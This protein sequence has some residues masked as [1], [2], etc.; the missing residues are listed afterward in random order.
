MKW[1]S[2]AAASGKAPWKRVLQELPGKDSKHRP[3]PARPNDVGQGKNWAAL[4]QAVT[5]QLSN[6]VYHVQV[7]YELAEYYALAGDEFGGGV[8]AEA[9]LNVLRYFRA[10]LSRITKYVKLSRCAVGNGQ[11]GRRGLKLGLASELSAVLADDMRCVAGQVMLLPVSLD[12]YT[13]SR[14]RDCRMVID[15]GGKRTT[16]E[17]SQFDGRCSRIRFDVCPS[18]SPKIALVHRRKTMG[19]LLKE[20]QE[21]EVQWMLTHARPL[22]SGRIMV[23]LSFMRESFCDG[24]CPTAHA[25]FYLEWF[26]KLPPPIETSHL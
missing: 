26:P 9:V 23:D 17:G 25:V 4:R 2:A 10:R 12:V 1:S 18:S 14:A 22:G 13:G 24:R 5:T 15:Y 7:S 11:R 20:E 3:P 19:F 6:F 16:I 8:R 21:G